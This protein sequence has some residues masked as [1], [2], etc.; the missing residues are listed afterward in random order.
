MI[1]AAAVQKPKRLRRGSRF[2]VVAPASPGKSDRVAGRPERT[3]AAGFFPYA[4]REF[5]LPM[6]ILQVA[7]IPVI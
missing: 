4:P 3:R 7:P 2:A 1:A 6:D 5:F